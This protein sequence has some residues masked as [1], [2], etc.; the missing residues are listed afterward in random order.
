[1]DYTNINFE[2]VEQG[3]ILGQARALEERAVLAEYEADRF[4]AI[5]EVNPAYAA[6]FPV[7]QEAAQKARKE[8][9]AFVAAAQKRQFMADED[10][11]VLRRDVLIRIIQAV[12]HEH[13]SQQVARDIRKA[14]GLPVPERDSAMDELERSWAV[15]DRKLKKLGKPKATKRTNADKN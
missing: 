11:S 12:E 1:M 14:A 4:A 15:A 9:D 10:I 3:T 8:A 13:A 2:E 6:Q 7:M 5:G